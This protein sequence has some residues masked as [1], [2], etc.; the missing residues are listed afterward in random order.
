MSFDPRSSKF[1]RRSFVLGGVQTGLLAALSGRLAW[2]QISQGNRYRMLSDK[3]RISI[4]MD[5]PERGEIMDRYGVPLA[6]NNK[7][8]RLVA[9][10]DQIKDFPELIDKVSSYVTISEVEKKRALKAIKR[11]SR[12]SSVEIKDG[13]NWQDV[14]RVEVKIA[15]LPGVQVQQS[16]TRSYPFGQAMAHIVGYVGSVSEKDLKKDSSPLLKATGFKIGKTGIE[17]RYEEEIRGAAGASEV[18]VNVVGREVR[19]LNE[20]KSV[21]GSRINL[22]IDAE[23]QRF[24]HQ[25]IASEKS[26]SAVIMDAHSG[27]IYAMSSH[28]S[29]EPNTFVQ[30][31]SSAKWQE[32]LA[33]PG[34]PL[35][36]KVIAGQ[37][38]PASTFKIITGLAALESGLTN[39]KHTVYC[40][41]YYEYG[42]DT[43]RFHCWK[44]G[45]HGWC[46]LTKALAESCD[47]YFYDLATQIGIDK[48]AQTARRF[49]LGSKLGFDLPQ[50]QPGLIPDK[51]WKL[52][53][54]GKHW[55][56]GET[57]VASIG[58]GYMLSTPLQLAV[59]TAR[60][61]NGGYAVEPWLTHSLG[62]AEIQEKRWPKMDVSEEYLHLLKKGMNAV[63]NT[64]KGTAYKSRI[65][66]PFMQMAG[67]TG[68]AQVQRITRA[69]RKAGIKNEDLEW[70]RRHHA[71]FVGYAPVENPKY[72]CS[73]VVEHGEGGSKTAAPI[74]KD[75]LSQVQRRGTGSALSLS[76]SS[77][78]QGG[79]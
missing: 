3:N 24:L 12:F 68:T 26:A 69:D 46:N 65:E 17:R 45:G 28:P 52:G 29:Y 30:G 21:Q 55:R 36:N 35:T 39:E 18:E 13:L 75:L 20:R 5:I 58:Q 48:I 70:K 31:I 47:V 16:Q 64:K 2:L 79:L 63:V 27:A 15:D 49:G 44:R 11:T 43:D 41:G 9:V 6:T 59:M 38:P 73:V 67:K 19:I 76:R 60:M 51:S 77:T 37:Y 7:M 61:V 22:S 1:T 74:A 8:F 71:L 32:L 33:T 78:D 53:A 23:L 4:K 14:S 34:T 66:E 57:I 25:R 50:E 62:G 56:P 42:V 72:V 40:K 10:P 54:K